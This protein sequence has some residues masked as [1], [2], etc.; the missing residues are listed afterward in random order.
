MRHSNCINM[1]YKK[2]PTAEMLRA[3][4]WGFGDKLKYRH[5]IL[6]KSPYCNA[7]WSCWGGNDG[8]ATLILHLETGYT[9]A[10]YSR[11]RAPRIYRAVGLSTCRNWSHLAL[12]GSQWFVINITAM[13]VWDPQNA[14]NLLTRPPLSASEGP[15]PSSWLL[16]TWKQIPSASNPQTLSSNRKNGKTWMFRDSY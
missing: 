13:T 12:D 8:T 11:E 10:L 14:G 1:V 4:N 6:K 5:C 9:S 7:H 3:G 16:Q 15:V 2:S